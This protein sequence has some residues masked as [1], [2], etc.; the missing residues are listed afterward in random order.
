MK[1]P[2]LMTRLSTTGAIVIVAVIALGLLY[3]RYARHPWTRNG[4][5]S[6]NIV[7]IAPRV[8][9]LVVE[10]GVTDNQPVEAG[11]LLFRIDP[12][13]FELAV[14]SAQTQLDQA[15]QN[16]ES[17]EAAIVAAEAAISEAEASV[18]TAKAQVDAAGAGLRSA[19]A[20]IDRSKAGLDQ[21]GR[22][23][24]RAEK[25][26]KDGAGSV[27]RAE[28]RKAAEEKAQ[29][30][31]DGSH[32]DHDEAVASLDQA[33]AGRAQ[34][35]ARLVSA[36]AQ[37]TQARAN[38]GTPG[39]ANVQIRAAKVNLEHAEHD[40]ERSEIRA[41]GD[42][43][44]TNLNVDVGDYASSGTA[45]LAFVDGASFHIEGYF[46]ETQLR[47]I[48]VG[49]R[50][51]VTLMSYRGKRIHG[52]VESIGWAINP[53]NIATTTGASG[54]VPQVQPSFDWIRLAQRV[55]V[56]IRIDRVPDGVQLIAGTT[57]S[58]VIW[59]ES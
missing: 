56:R 6:A 26:S 24:E 53:P 49:D 13:D 40:L 32:A 11:D 8:T 10:V 57:A 21:A 31:L 34:A 52:T 51:V 36:R 3:L 5:V 58:V 25:L 4:Q 2:K 18:T 37:L 39:E 29:A 43:Y 14:A 16:V 44:I 28:S 47:H 12:T 7:M 33:R 1:K 30:T 35:D 23:R 41:P 46:R 22:D 15:R 59:P 55:P 50:A 17:L 19:Q 20:S 45:L 48:E 27:S 38:L 42:G 9:G 54:L